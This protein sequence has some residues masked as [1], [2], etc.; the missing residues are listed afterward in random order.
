MEVQGQPTGASIGWLERQMEVYLVGGAV[1]DELLGLPVRE[2]DW[3]VVGGSAKALLK[4]GYRQVGRDFPVFLHPKTHEQYALARTERKTAPGH[5][6]FSTQADGDVSLEADLV[7]RD[8]TINAIA[9]DLQ[10]RL[11]D[12][13]GG[14]RDLRERRLRHV[15]QAFGED[16]LRVFRVARFAAVLEGFTVHPDTL[17]L[18]ESMAGALVELP[19]ERVWG[20]FRKAL[21]GPAPQRFVEVLKQ[22]GCLSP[23][24]LELA[25][26]AIDAALNDALLRYGGI[27]WELSAAD[28]RA[29]GKRLKVP[30]VNLQLSL[31]VAR[32][33]KTLAAWR[34]LTAVDLDRVLAAINGYRDAQRRR[35]VF[36]VVAAK[37]GTS[38]RRLEEA[39]AQAEVEI[40][41]KRR[42]W[43]VLMGAAVGRR[44]HR[45]RLAFFARFLGQSG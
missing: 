25:E 27:G 37:S 13:F 8:L 34:S 29:L 6:G 28:A 4:Q 42:D 26:V 30:K 24:L 23:W 2:R 22:A 32:R 33:G 10:G 21:D 14:Q 17:A 35:R 38:M 45:E 43:P 1:R 9:K 20:E 5:A 41:N 40:A 31:D 15:S 39:L 16:P 19:A 12:P 44:M 3:L 18:M 11:I 7:R 36:A